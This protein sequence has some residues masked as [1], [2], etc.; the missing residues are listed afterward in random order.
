MLSDMNI[1]LAHAYCT[2][3]PTC[4]IDIDDYRYAK[5]WLSSHMIDLA[6]MLHAHDASVIW[7]GKLFSLKILYRLPSGTAPLESKKIVGIDG[8]SAITNITLKD[9]YGTSLEIFKVSGILTS[10]NYDI[11]EGQYLLA[12]AKITQTIP[13]TKTLI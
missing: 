12:S 11:S 5:K 6:E 4:A 9:T 7:S 10:Q 13:E 1:G 2:P 8:K 3:T